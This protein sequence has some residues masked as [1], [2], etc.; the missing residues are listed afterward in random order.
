MPHIISQDDSMRAAT[1][2]RLKQFAPVKLTTTKDFV[3]ECTAAVD[4]VFGIM[5]NK[6]NVGETGRVIIKGR[7][8]ARV[9][10]ASTAIAINDRL[11]PNAAG[12]ALVKKLAAGANVCAIALDVCTIANG[13]IDVNL[14]CTTVVGLVPPTS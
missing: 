10:G 12:T 13:I 11:G 8:S 9:D 5:F 3:T 4:P 14:D 1:D 2:M 6:P 7:M